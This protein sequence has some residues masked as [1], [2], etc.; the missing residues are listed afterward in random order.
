MSKLRFFNLYRSLYLI[1]I[2]DVLPRLGLLI[3][4]SKVKENILD[5]YLVS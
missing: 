1:M 5:K 4:V 3:R 2:M